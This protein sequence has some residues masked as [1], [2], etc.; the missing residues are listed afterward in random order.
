LV[1]VVIKPALATTAVLGLVFGLGYVLVPTQVSALFG[2]AIDLV[3]QHMARNFG[4][5]LL[6]IATIA[7][8][9]RSATDPVTLRGISL[10]FCI[11]F[12]LGAIS[13]LLFQRMGLASNFLWFAITFHILLA[14]P[15]GYILIAKP[16]DSDGRL[17]ADVEPIDS[18][19]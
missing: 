10:G 7:W 9:A 14:L 18:S 13:I 12:A 6:A 17:R 19:Q 15:F 8:T 2:V 1:K 5:A 3:S 4:S 16:D 11:Y